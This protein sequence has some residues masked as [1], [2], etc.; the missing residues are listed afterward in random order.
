MIAGRMADR[1]FIGVFTKKCRVFVVISTI[2][3][4]FVTQFF[5]KQTVQCM[6]PPDW[7]L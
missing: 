6:I 1:C 7:A 4:K 5:I 3:P 2:L